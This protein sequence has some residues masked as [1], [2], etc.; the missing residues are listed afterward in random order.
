MAENLKIY[1]GNT[2]KMNIPAS[3]KQKLTCSSDNPS[4]ADVNDGIIIALGLG[5]ATIT[6][7]YPSKKETI[8]G[9]IKV[10]VLPGKHKNDEN[11]FS[12]QEGESKV[13]RAYAV[14]GVFDSVK[15]S[16]NKPQVVSV[17]PS[18]TNAI[19]RA[20]SP[21]IATIYSKLDVGGK[22]TSKKA[23]VT[24]EKKSRT[25]PLPIAN[26]LSGSELTENDDWL[27]SRVYFGSFMQKKD[28]RSA[29]EPILWRVLEITDDYVFLLAEYGLICRNI[30]EGLTDYSWDT[31]P[32]RKWLNNDFLDIAFTKHEAGAIQDSIVPTDHNVKRGIATGE[33][34]IDKVFILSTEEATNPDYGFMP[35][36]N[37]ASR[38]RYLKCTEFAVD[39]GGYAQPTNGG[40]CWWL[41]TPG[42]GTQYASYVFTMGKITDW[43][44]VGRRHDAIRPAIKVKLNDIYFAAPNTPE[45][46]NDDFYKI[47]VK[48]P[49]I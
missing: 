49:L 19:L 3:A 5:E 6:Y 23:Y 2:E 8:S 4:V 12:M 46:P 35:G 17:E 15:Y 14:K 27:G 20:L 37:K 10:T 26:P 1:Y 47:M 18:G 7:S 43:Y 9:T 48:S 34:T 30:T 22:Q 41:R 44:F 29:S 33:D 38:T 36:I 25:L 32:I 31:C 16:S 42:C 21:G 40:T 13:F 24:V 45:N 39:N 28:A 11:I